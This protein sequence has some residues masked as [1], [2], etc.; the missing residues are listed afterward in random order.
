MMIRERAEAL[1][2]APAPLSFGKASRDSMLGPETR[3]PVRSRLGHHTLLQFLAFRSGNHD[4]QIA[5][6]LGTGPLGYF[7]HSALSLGQAFV[8]YD[9][10]NLNPNHSASSLHYCNLFLPASI[11]MWVRSSTSGISGMKFARRAFQV[12]LLHS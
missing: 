4:S 5:V 9:R 8:H 12:R 7:S 6:T 11:R 2:T 1:S 3:W 10:R